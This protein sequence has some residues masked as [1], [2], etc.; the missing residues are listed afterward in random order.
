MASV[1]AVMSI[2]PFS[3]FAP[4]KVTVPVVLLV[5]VA[6]PL[7]TALTTP[8]ST[9]KAVPV[10]LPSSTVPSTKRNAPTLC[11][12]APSA[13]T[14]DEPLTVSIPLVNFPAPPIA[15]VPA[16]TS[17]RP[18]S[19]LAPVSV[20]APSVL[21]LTVA[22]PLRTA[23]IKP[24]S[25]PKLAA[26]RLP[27]AT[28]PSTKRNAPTLCSV[29]PRSNTV[30]ALRTVSEPLVSLPRP[31]TSN[32]PLVMSIKPVSVFAPASVTVPAEVLVKLAPPLRTLLRRPFSTTYE[33]A[34]RLPF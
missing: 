17:I 15:S 34:V 22:E 13:S 32:S 21:L 29:V 19:V 8:F 25:M 4:L 27:F 23:P 9:L 12:V 26:V 24:F 10:R 14:V 7:S 1:P 16:V 28:V 30:A 2:A 3:V 33:A 5:N 11:R 18:V 20:T 31:V 6:P